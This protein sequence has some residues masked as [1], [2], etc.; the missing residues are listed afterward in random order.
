MGMSYCS[1]LRI[2]FYDDSSKSG[3]IEILPVYTLEGYGVRVSSNIVQTGGTGE[4]RYEYTRKVFDTV[5]LACDL[6]D[7]DISD[8]YI[9]CFENFYYNTITSEAMC[10]VFSSFLVEY[11]G[12]YISTLRIELHPRFVDV[13]DTKQKRIGYDQITEKKHVGF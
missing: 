2:P 4:N 7:N 8:L 9:E 11:F 10:T 13:C 12:D 6:N 3:Y 1:V 5:V